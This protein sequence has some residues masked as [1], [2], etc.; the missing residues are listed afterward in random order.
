MV[1][2]TFSGLP[3]PVSASAI[4]GTPTASTI[5]RALEAI[6]DMPSRPT[7]G[8]SENARG[9]AEARHIHGGKAGGFNQPCAQGIVGAGRQDWFTASHQLPQRSRPRT[10]VIQERV[11]R[12]GLLRE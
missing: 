6:S 7:F 8:P 2:I 5:C 12:V 11:H 9:G 3:Y 10:A 1:R 4:R